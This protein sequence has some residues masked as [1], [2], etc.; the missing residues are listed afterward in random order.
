MGIAVYE[1]PESP[2]LGDDSAERRYK[3]EGTLQELV[4]RTTLL[5]ASP[6]LFATGSQTLV[7]QTARVEPDDADVWSG[8]ITY[9]KRKRPETGESTYQLDTGGGTQHI[10]HSIKTV[11]KYAPPGKTAP[12]FKGAIGHIHS[13]P[14]RG[15]GVLSVR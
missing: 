6:V 11:G 8:I 7:R 3:I 5:W 2:T 15:C 9:G 10:T 1:T 12:D 14:E 13:T 4:A